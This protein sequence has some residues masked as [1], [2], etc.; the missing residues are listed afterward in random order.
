MQIVPQVGASVPQMVPQVFWQVLQVP[1]QLLPQ[2]LQ[3]PPQLLPHVLQ[4]EPQVLVP[5][6]HRQLGPCVV[7]VQMMLPPVVPS[8]VNPNTVPSLCPSEPGVV[9]NDSTWSSLK[10]SL[11]FSMVHIVLSVCVQ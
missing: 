10:L 7:Q 6:G 1:P 9:S 4:V 5:V 3:V 8:S 2:V 11:I